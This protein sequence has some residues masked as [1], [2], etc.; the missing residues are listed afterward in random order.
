M[1]GYRNAPPSGKKISRRG[2][3]GCA[4]RC[5]MGRNAGRRTDRSSSA[6]AS[7]V[8]LLSCCDEPLAVRR[9]THKECDF[10]ELPDESAVVRYGT[11]PKTA[12]RAL[13]HA[14]EKRMSRS[15]PRGAAAVLPPGSA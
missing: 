15:R 13:R 9:F 10:L 12:R 14:S 7:P 8:A 6:S 11:H 1:C 5:E 3:G 4:T 2:S